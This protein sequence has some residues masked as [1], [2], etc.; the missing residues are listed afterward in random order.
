M[1]DG[2]MD[3]E[4]REIGMYVRINS[5]SWDDIGLYKVIK[6]Q[7]FEINQ[8]ST[9]IELTLEDS[10]GATIKKTVPAHWVEWIKDEER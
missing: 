8:A 9:A 2:S 5:D 7:L 4:D 1:E 3:L 6:Y 10:S